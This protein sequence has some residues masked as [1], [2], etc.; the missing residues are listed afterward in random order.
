MSTDPL[1]TEYERLRDDAIGGMYLN[2]RT[3]CDARWLALDA[4]VA[5]LIEAV[6]QRESKP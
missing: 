5:K 4:F 2:Q 1:R 6:R 3:D